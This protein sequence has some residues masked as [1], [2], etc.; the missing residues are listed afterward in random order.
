MLISKVLGVIWGSQVYALTIPLGY[1]NFQIV[2][3]QILNIL[4][5]IR[6][7]QTQWSDKKVEIACD[8]QAVVQV[9]TSG[10]TRDLTLAAISRNISFQA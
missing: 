10:K 8:N 1:T 4:A 5:A 6:L 7:W 3:L 2:H 9:L